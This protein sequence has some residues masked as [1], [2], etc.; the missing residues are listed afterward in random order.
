MGLQEHDLIMADEKFSGKTVKKTS[1]RACWTKRL[2][3]VS[4]YHLK[5]QK[6]Q[7][8]W[9]R[10]ISSQWPNICWHFN[11][12]III[13]PCAQT[14]EQRRTVTSSWSH[15][16]KWGS[17]F[18]SNK[19][20]NCSFLFHFLAFDSLFPILSH[21]IRNDRSTLRVVSNG[22]QKTQWTRT[23]LA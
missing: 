17:K 6:L 16:A 15:R 21:K 13:K 10:K 2:G 7:K 12:Q 23:S 4:K 20:I 3:Q 1:S 8:Q 18:A 19:T 11:N 22:F 14:H 5:I 9:I